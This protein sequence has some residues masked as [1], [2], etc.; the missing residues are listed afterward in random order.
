MGALRICHLY[1]DIMN[2]YGDRG[3]VLAIERRL[4]W[5]GLGYELREASLGD[6]V[7]FGD[8]DLILF[9]GGQD[10]EQRLVCTDLEGGCRH[11]EAASKREAL[12][13][14]LED[15]VACLGICGGYQ[16]LGRYYRTA[17][18]EI[19]PG[20][21]I[22]DAWTEGGGRRLIGNIVI[23]SDLGGELEGD[24]NPV[25]HPAD[26]GIKGRGKSLVGFENHSG[27]TYLAQV[28]GLRPLGRVKAGFGNNGGDGTEGAV[29]KHV[30][31][32]YMHGA[33]L[34]KNPW[35]AD[36]L[37]LWGL[38]RRNPGAMLPRRLDDTFEEEA[39]RAAVAQAFKKQRVGA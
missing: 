2:L 17:A 29:Y 10:R 30:V 18:G 6:D 25:H 1:P 26:D 34:P 3:N 9:G 27:R 20:V 24:G 19:L 36:L 12:R 28:D 8:F 5:Y 13:V 22:L 15:G 7:E 16:L 39:H 4:D 21:G 33:L 38:R 37:I 14:A 23:E 35:L 32:T 11:L 31:G